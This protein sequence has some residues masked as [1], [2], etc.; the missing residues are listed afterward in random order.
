M[1]YTYLGSRG[2]EVDPGEALSKQLTVALAELDA[3][4]ASS[5]SK[6][7]SST[8]SSSNASE[9]LLLIRS[10]D[11]LRRLQTHTNDSEA[12][13]QA[14]RKYAL[15]CNALIASHGTR[16]DALAVGFSLT[17]ELVRQTGWQAE[18]GLQ[19]FGQE[20]LQAIMSY[21]LAV[22]GG[23][24]QAQQNRL[25]PN[26]AVLG[27]LLQLLT[28]YILSPEAAARPEFARAVVTPNMP[29]ATSALVSLAESAGSSAGGEELDV[30][31]LL[32]VLPVL[33]SQLALHPSLYR[34]F[35]ARLHSLAMPLL[36]NATSPSSLSQASVGLVHA[37]HLTGAQASSS[38]KDAGSSS[39]PGKKAT[40]AQLWSATIRAALGSTREAWESCVSTFDLGGDAS[41]GSSSERLSFA[42]LPEEPIAAFGMGSKQLDH[43]L[44]QSGILLQLLQL[45]TPRP[46][47]IPLTSLV[48]LALAMLSVTAETPSR[49]SVDASLH[50]LQTLHLVDLHLKAL[51]LL[52]YSVRTVQSAGVAAIARYGPHILDAVV[53]LLERGDR[54]ASSVRASASRL[55]TVL[56][57]DKSSP[58]SAAGATLILD[59]A[60]RITLRTA[61]AMLSEIAR[62]LSTSTTSQ[63][64]KQD[65]PSAGSTQSSNA[66]ARK[67]KRT[68]P[69]ESDSLFASSSQS[70]SILT[71]KTVDE[72]CSA[73]ACLQVFPCLLPHLCTDLTA[74]HYDVAHSGVQLIVALGEITLRQPLSGSND[75]WIPLATATLRAL[76]QCVNQV[77]GPLLGL[78]APR[79][80]NL[81]TTA[82]HL[83]PL[84]LQQAARDA[85]EVL[86]TVTLPRLP[87]VLASR[88]NVEEEETMDWGTDDTTGKAITAKTGAILMDP[89][90]G[91]KGT[92]TITAIRD[93]VGIQLGQDT[94]R[95]ALEQGREETPIRSRSSLSPARRTAST[96]SSFPVPPRHSSPEVRP[97]SPTADPVKP[98]A[99]PSTPRIGSPHRVV[100][101]GEVGL[102]SAGSPE[103]KE[104]FGGGASSSIRRRVTS[105]SPRMGVA[106]SEGAALVPGQDTVAMMGSSVP[107]KEEV[108]QRNQGVELMVDSDD[109]EMPEIDLGSSDEDD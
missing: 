96:P 10:T 61:R 100:S 43:L 80:S 44:G 30:S 106:A 89:L 103:A 85:T 54:T 68:N 28:D 21:L 26:P 74:L 5:S 84:S 38:G 51:G 67:K 65:G 50:S 41:Q 19:R 62:L 79:L 107:T 13:S 39:G 82:L 75:Q 16:S 22:T 31:T 58:S 40:Q 99:R 63:S 32:L 97:G 14:L 83:G 104:V 25:R 109:E 27:P 20:W 9:L 36:L 87:P 94:T 17:L 90:N 29:K 72:R 101:A 18:D 4:L 56:L 76:S 93:V 6:A 11:L 42:A 77:S 35:A 1:A 2:R 33:A 92:T 57:S 59:P 95:R 55:L 71:H 73:I 3:G 8:S 47:P 88:V 70:S 7:S 105:P 108:L 24:A 46:V 49:S 60:A 78:L 86:R 23:S 37:L 64:S 48:S 53:R 66:P 81:A 98:V 69:Y 34:P 52:V 91:G 12:A 102:P 15:R 45:P